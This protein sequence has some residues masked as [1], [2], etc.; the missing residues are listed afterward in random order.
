M[1]TPGLFNLGTRDIIKGFITSIL[2]SVLTA[3]ITILNTGNI[4]MDL[5]SWKPTLVTGIA[6]G[7]GYLLKNF[8]TNSNDQFGKPEVKTN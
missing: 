4:P 8:L 3:A 6:T 5:A 2:S 7:L 1:K